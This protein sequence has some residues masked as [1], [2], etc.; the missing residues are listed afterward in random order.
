MKQPTNHRELEE[1]QEQP[2]RVALVA[3]SL[4]TGLF[5]LLIILVILGSTP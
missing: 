2:M 4:L 3:V 5:L 1:F